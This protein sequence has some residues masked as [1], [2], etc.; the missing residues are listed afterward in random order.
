MKTLDGTLYRRAL[1][2]SGPQS[3]H[4]R[5][6][7]RA[8]G[9]SPLWV[10]S[11]VLTVGMSLPVFPDD[12]TSPVSVSMSQTCHIRKWSDLFDHLVGAGKQRRRHGEA[13]RLHGRE[14]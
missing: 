12:R 2:C 9:Q 1:D 10:K 4:T 5:V 14:V 11:G 8:G 13:E 7:S 6:V 3:A